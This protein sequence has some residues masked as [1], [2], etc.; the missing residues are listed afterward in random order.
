MIVDDAPDG[1]VVGISAVTPPPR[2]ATQAG[3]LD[4]L[5]GGDVHHRSDR[6]AAAAVVAL[7]PGA[8]EATRLARAYTEYAVS[9][10]TGLDYEQWIDCHPGYPLGGASSTVEIAAG[11]RR[12]GIARVI[13]VDD[14]RTVLAA[15]RAHRPAGLPETATVEVIDGTLSDPWGLLHS[16][17]AVHAAGKATLGPP[18][19]DL[20][21]PVALLLRGALHHIE[22]ADQPDA[23]LRELASAL[24]SGS[25]VVAV[26]LVDDEHLDRGMIRDVAAVLTDRGL[27]V[28]PRSTSA[29]RSLIRQIPGFDEL[30]PIHRVGPSVI[31][32]I[33][34]I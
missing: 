23:L 12:T 2:P 33:G 8:V 1:V 4:A 17:H 22:D 15:H 9:R 20:S 21:R 32:G 30:D 28:V 31:G 26:H 16:L 5:L 25:A 18:L 3:V 19:L 10:L 7:F 11:P 13:V 29:A 27:R 34:V 6:D 24:P 14:D